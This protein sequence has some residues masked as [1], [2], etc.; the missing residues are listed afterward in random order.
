M[1]SKTD[2]PC[3]LTARAAKTIA[4]PAL[5]YQPRSPRQYQPSIGLIACGRI[6]RHHLTAYR[7]AGY[8]VAGL[9]DLVP[10]RARERQ[11]EF[12]PDAKVYTDYRQILK[13]DDIEVV[14]IAT[15]P[16]E[17][18]PIIEAALVAGKHVLSQKPL[19]LDLDFGQRMV[20]LADRQG[21]KFAVNQNGRWAPHFS[22]AR[23]AI[24]AGLL[25]DVTGAHLS[26][27]WDH[28]WVHGTEFDNVKHLILYDFAIHWFDILTCFLGQRRPIRVYA[29]L[30]RSPGQSARPALLGQAL[31]EY[32]GAQATLAFDAD[33]RF[34]PQDRTYVTGTRGSIAS[35]GPD[36]KSQVLTLSTA[37][38]RATPSLEGQWFSDG[39][40]GTMG[41]LLCAIEDSREPYNSA[42][43]NLRSLELCFAAV[44]SAE[45][46]RPVVPG[47]IRKLPS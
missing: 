7:H 30:A 13:R 20:D 2:D 19:A 9:C 21:V 39:F 18:V 33:T 37:D 10:E 11:K 25:G 15:H 38:G 16:P 1:S 3:T 17:R 4:A 23:Q 32:D 27:H 26:V 5:P 42:R 46:H 28:N 6:T 35:V 31:V 22:Y 45:C 41:E 40:H 34:G 14:D 8:R 12:Y 36:L 43:N 29:S 24:Q 47:T 44:A